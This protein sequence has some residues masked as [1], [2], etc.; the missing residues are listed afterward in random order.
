MFFSCIPGYYS[1]LAAVM[2]YGSPRLKK[3][4]FAMLASY[5]AVPISMF[6]VIYSVMC[7]ASAMS[8]SSFMLNFDDQMCQLSPTVLS[9][10]LLML[11]GQAAH[12]FGREFNDQYKVEFDEDGKLRKEHHEQ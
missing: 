10:F 2:K 3:L 9:A 8:A 7:F 6:A 11:L 12:I 4:Y 1:D 5:V